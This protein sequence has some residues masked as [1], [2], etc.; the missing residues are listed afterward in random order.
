MLGLIKLKWKWYRRV[1]LASSVI[2]S[3]LVVLA[4]INS[5]INFLLV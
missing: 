1:Y 3:V 2:N 5:V 4:V